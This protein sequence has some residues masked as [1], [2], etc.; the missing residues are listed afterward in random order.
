MQRQRHRS[1]LLL[2]LL[3]AAAASLLVHAQSATTAVTGPAVVLPTDDP[4]TQADRDAFIGS[5]ALVGQCQ[6]SSTCCC[7]TGP[8]TI[9][10][11]HACTCAARR[12]QTT[13]AHH[14]LSS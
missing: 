13:V 10:G 8:V 1:L 12:A 5:Y 9:T 4:H 7:A 2:L 3:G 11:E 14:L 6:P